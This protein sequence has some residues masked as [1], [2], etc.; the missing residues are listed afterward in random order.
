MIRDGTKRSFRCC[1]VALLAA[2]MAVFA[3]VSVVHNHG[4]PHPIPGSATLERPSAGAIQPVNFCLACLASHVPAPAPAGQTLLDAPQ[5][6][7]GVLSVGPIQ[8][9][10]FQPLGIAS[11]RAPPSPRSLAA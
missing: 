11:P 4:L 1:F 7:T 6:V 5:V 9:H 2:W 10:A 3:V 8:F